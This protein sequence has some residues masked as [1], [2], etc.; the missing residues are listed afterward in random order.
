MNLLFDTHALITLL[1]KEPG[2]LVVQ[3]LFEEIEAGISKSFLSTVTIA[4]IKY[5]FVK[6]FGDKEAEIRLH[7]IIN[8]GLTI[9]PVSIPIALSA[10]S[11]KNSGISLADAMI[12]ATAID[13]AA[14]V[15]TGDRHFSRMGIEVR[16][17]P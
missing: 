4:E 16:N 15:V 9:I 8:S 12:A 14:V 6:R 11:L 10:G 17:Y 2:Y 1:H 7:T 5:L 13:L 3:S